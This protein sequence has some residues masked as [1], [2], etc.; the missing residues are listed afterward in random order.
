MLVRSRA[1]IFKYTYKKGVMKKIILIISFLII[2]TL[3]FISCNSAKNNSDSST[4]GNQEITDEI[5][6]ESDEIWSKDVQI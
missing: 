4:S 3:C 6:N 2:S 1:Q 5:G